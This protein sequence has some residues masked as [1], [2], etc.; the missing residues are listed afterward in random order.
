MLSI[1][2]QL[3]KDYVIDLKFEF[4]SPLNP[5]ACPFCSV[6]HFY[7]FA[8]IYSNFFSILLFWS[9]MY[10]AGVCLYNEITS[11]TTIF[12]MTLK[13]LTLLS[14]ALCFRKRL[15]ISSY[16]GNHLLPETIVCHRQAYAWS[17]FCSGLL[18]NYAIYD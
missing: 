4:E 3:V 2:K 6:S 8:Q 15:V 18:V 7:F 17:K 10:S 5:P 12:K 14:S 16:F 1:E 13:I 9:K 11:V